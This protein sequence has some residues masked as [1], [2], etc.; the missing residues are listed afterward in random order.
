[1]LSLIKN[2]VCLSHHLGVVWRADGEV[3]R[4]E[5]V[6]DDQRRLR[7]GNGGPQER[8]EQHL[9]PMV[10]GLE[11]ANGESLWPVDGLGAMLDCKVN[12]SISEALQRRLHAAPFAKCAELPDRGSMSLAW[13]LLVAQRTRLDL[14]A[15]LRHDRCAV[16]NVGLSQARGSRIYGQNP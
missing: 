7:F 4:L 9:L 16:D 15:I 14:P 5:G 12:E 8:V 6:Q 10:V 13:S 2:G 11:P 3:G 1:M